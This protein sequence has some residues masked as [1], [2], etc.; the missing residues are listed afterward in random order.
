MLLTSFAISVTILGYIHIAYNLTRLTTIFKV[1]FS[2]PSIM[3]S[4]FKG[5]IIV[6]GCLKSI[7]S[8]PEAFGNLT[9]W[10]LYILS[11]TI[12]VV[13]VLLPAITSSVK[14]TFELFFKV[15]LLESM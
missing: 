3:C 4:Y 9:G 5:Q 15:L 12:R 10:H 13:V 11:F 6:L 1:C 7:G 2:S 14:A 8:T